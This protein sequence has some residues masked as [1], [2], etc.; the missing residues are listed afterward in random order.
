[1]KKKVLL[2]ALLILPISTGI[3]QNIF[4]AGGSFTVMSPQDAFNDNVENL[5]FGLN[6]YFAYRFPRSPILA[7]VSAS[8]N[9]YGTQTWSEPLAGPVFV[10]VTTTNALINAFLFLRIE[11][12]H[13]VVRPYADALL[14][15]N[16]LT[17]DSR[18][19]DIDEYEEIA[20]SKN[21]DDFTS[22]YGLGGGLHIRVWQATEQLEGPSALHID[23]GF[24]YIKGGEARYLKKGGIEQVGNNFIYHINRSTT[25]YLSVNIGVSVDF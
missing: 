24:R 3:A 4:Q 12:A 15:F 14:G 2:L 1:M 9:I 13:G 8:F 10:D 18:I 11:P 21:F 16:Y 19:D 5:G 20:S 6:G 7:G 23:L 22:A 17:T 25:N